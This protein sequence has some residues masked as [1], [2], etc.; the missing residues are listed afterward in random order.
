MSLSY[1]GSP[2]RRN[3]PILLAKTPRRF[4]TPKQK[5]PP[6]RARREPGAAKNSAS[7]VRGSNVALASAGMNGLSMKRARP[8]RKRAHTRPWSG[9]RWSAPDAACAL[10]VAVRRAQVGRGELEASAAYEESRP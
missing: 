2:E 6:V 1:G 5:I 8:R 10:V 3:V 9:N 4:R 7:P